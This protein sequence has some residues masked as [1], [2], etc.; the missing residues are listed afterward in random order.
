MFFDL[1][2]LAH[3]RIEILDRTGLPLVIIVGPDGAPFSTWQRFVEAHRLG[4]GSQRS[5][6]RS[7][8]L[9]IDFIT[10]NSDA[11]L[12]Q[13]ERHRMFQA[14]ADALVL[15]TVKEGTDPSGL[16]W[17]PHSAR[18]AR[19][20]VV[21]VTAF[22]DWL[23]ESGAANPVNPTRAATLA[24]RLAFWQAWQ[25]SSN[26]SLLRHLKSASRARAQANT[27]RVVDARRR[28]PISTQGAKAFLEE[29][30][31]DLLTT[32]FRHPRPLRWTTMRDQMI[33]LLLHGGGLRLSE[34]LHLWVI[35]VFKAPDDPNEAL[36]KVFHP[37][38][39]LVHYRDPKSGHTRPLRRAEYLR[40]VY[41][42]KPLTDLPGRKAVGWKDPLLT[43]LHERSM[44]M[45]WRSH[46][47]G[48]LF[49]RLYRAYVQARPRVSRHP[50]LFVA[51][52][53]EPMTVKAYENPDNGIL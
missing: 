23:Y 28:E 7:L 9:F 53:G 18:A 17:F 15:G 21:E 25:R 45:F 5:Y 3:S 49:M 37:S 2:P 35:D 34:A 1:P 24:E 52:G 39:G 20:A 44:F 47:Y 11:F 12:P 27:A 31:A 22:T 32:G 26:A 41:D 43:D 10:T 40:L 48:R 4:I 46:G 42:R 29:L 8:G 50:Y 6:A 38:E 16:W 30:F 51:T 36:V 14:F 13:T 33:A 19:R